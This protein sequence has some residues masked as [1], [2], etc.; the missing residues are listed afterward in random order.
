MS[1]RELLWC[2]PK[3]HGR[4]LHPRGDRPQLE[5]SVRCPDYLRLLVDG[6]QQVLPEGT[7]I[8]AESS[9]RGL[10]PRLLAKFL[11]GDPFRISRDQDVE[12]L[13][14]SSQEL[15]APHLMK[16]FC[17]LR[18]FRTCFAE[19]VEALLGDLHAA[20]VVLLD[21]VI[22][23][24]CA[25]IGAERSSAGGITGES[26]NLGLR[27]RT[28]LKLGETLEHLSLAG[29]KVDLVLA[30]RGN[31]RRRLH[32]LRFL[33]RTS[34]RSRCRTRRG[35]LML[36]LLDRL[37]NL[38]ENLG[39]RIDYGLKRLDRTAK[40]GLR[41]L[42]PLG[43]LLELLDLPLLEYR[44][45]HDAI[46]DL[47]GL[48]DDGGSFRR[49]GGS[50]GLLGELR[51]EPLN[52]RAKQFRIFLLGLLDGLGHVLLETIKKAKQED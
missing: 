33:D 5:K 23:P 46:L 42:D 29:K 51:L 7:Q 22:L 16:L 40:T 44:D 47:N 21:Q 17:G 32:N 24:E 50:R 38:P 25:E 45:L 52:L 13:P 8:G 14:L 15:T 20:R 43:Q 19:P 26:S 11:L 18:R 1:F 10:I 2:E 31:L 37:R 34:R 4:I 48:D 12:H 49:R 30:V 41:L 36:D 3:L 28:R 9:S 27:A 35:R 39:D 6:C